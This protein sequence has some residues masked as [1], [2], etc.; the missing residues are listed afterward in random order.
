LALAS[1]GW[2]ST[3]TIKTRPTGGRMHVPLGRVMAS[4]IMGLALTA[5]AAAEG[6]PD[7]LGTQLGMPARDAYAKVQASL[8]KNNLQVKTKTF[9]TIEKPVL[10]S[11]VSVPQQAVGMGME[12]DSL[13]VYVT[14]PPNKPAVWYAERSHLFP[15]KGIART[16]LL[17][18]MRKK[19]GKETVAWIVR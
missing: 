7:I 10:T 16:T 9:P 19:Y 1:T 3:E 4:I 14:L 8:P 15:D 17:N 6:M 5:N 18:S 13:T 2:G 12:G 11:L